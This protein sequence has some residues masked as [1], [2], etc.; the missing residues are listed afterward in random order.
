LIRWFASLDSSADRLGTCAIT[1]IGF[2]RVSIHAGLER[3]TPGAVQ[4]LEGLKTSSRIPFF[5]IGDAL[6]ASHLPWWMTGAKQVTDGHLLGLAT[7]HSMELA[8]LD[9]GI[10]RAFLIP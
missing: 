4:T 10:P 2:V 5:L 9:K 1:E 3:D 8:T 7:Q 6:G